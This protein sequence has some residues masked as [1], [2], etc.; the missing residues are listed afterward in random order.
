MTILQAFIKQLLVFLIVIAY[1]LLKYIVFYESN[2]IALPYYFKNKYVISI[3]IFLW[4][5]VGTWYYTHLPVRGMW[6][7][8]L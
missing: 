6:L 3:I 2:G 7:K 4:F 1:W 5:G 8:I